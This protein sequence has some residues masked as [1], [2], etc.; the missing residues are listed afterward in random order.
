MKSQANNRLLFGIPEF[1]SSIATKAITTTSVLKMSHVQK[2]ECRCMY[3]ED[4]RYKIN[5]KTTIKNSI[6]NLNSFAQDRLAKSIPKLSA[7][8]ITAGHFLQT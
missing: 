2:L 7:A 3:T 1:T 8:T 6:N 5:D 4:T